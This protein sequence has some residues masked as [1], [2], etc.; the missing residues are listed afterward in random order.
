[1]G[2]L[3]PVLREEGTAAAELDG[4]VADAVVAERLREC[5]EVQTPITEAA[6]DA[7]AR[8]GTEVEVLVEGSDDERGDAVGRT[9]REAPE[10]DGVVR[11]DG[12]HAR[13]GSRVRAKVVA[14]E[15]ID[16]VAEPIEVV[17]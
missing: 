10:I 13:L 2:G 11:L 4:V 14:S 17:A 3:L 8:A 6:R 12:A 16:L 1:M 15:G 9:H 5:A 7:L